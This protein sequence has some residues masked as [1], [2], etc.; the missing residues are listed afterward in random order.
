MLFKQCPNCKKKLKF[1]ECFGLLH[2]AYDVCKYCQKPFQVKRKSIYIHAAINGATIGILARS[3]TNWNL[4][5][6]GVFAVVWVYFFQRFI[7][8]F[9]ELEP[10]D[11]DVLH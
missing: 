2:Q 4:F 11:D 10:A 5:E 7:D 3:M 8:F 9:Y 1:N 6:I